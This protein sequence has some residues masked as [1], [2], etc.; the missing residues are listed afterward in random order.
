ML[1]KG[2]WTSKSKDLDAFE[3]AADKFDYGMDKLNNPHKQSS[4]V[5]TN[6]IACLEG[7]ILL[8]TEEC[9]QA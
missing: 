8:A 7:D 1:R 4:W 2:N 6:F 3:Y 9:N 5:D